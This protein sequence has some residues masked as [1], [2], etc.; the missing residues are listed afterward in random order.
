MG[1]ADYRETLAG[2]SVLLVDDEAIV[3]EVIREVIGPMVSV[4]ASASNGI[5]ALARILDRDFDFILMDIEMPRMNGIE[6]YRH[7]SETKP[8]LLK[9]VIFI[10]GDTETEVTRSFIKKSGCLYLDKPFMIK[11]LLSVMSRGAY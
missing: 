11:D 10:T 6:L 2:R 4:F 7:I 8:H 5:E 3:V 1:A 9:K